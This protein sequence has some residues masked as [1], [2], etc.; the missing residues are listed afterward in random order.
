MT[1]R[2]RLLLGYGYLVG[3]LLVSTFSAVLGFLHL[4][5]GIDRVLE[6]N[7][8][9]IEAAMAMLETLERQ[10]SETLSALLAGATRG[11]T[12]TALDQDLNAALDR[13]RSHVTE[14]AEREA[15][16]A[17]VDGV[18]GFRHARDELLEQRADRPLAAYNEAVLPQFLLAKKRVRV[19]LDV[20]QE[21]MLAA[22]REAKATALRNGAWLGFLVAL[23]LLSLAYL[24]HAMQRHILS[25]IT[26]LR[27]DVE[28][29]TEGDPDRRLREGGDDELAAVARGVNCLVDSRLERQGELEARLALERRTLLGLLREAGEG[30]SLYDL[31]GRLRGVEGRSHDDGALVG[32]AT[33][34]RDEGKAFVEANEP[35]VAA[36]IGDYEVR[37]LKAGHDR[38][39]AW[40]AVPRASVEHRQQPSS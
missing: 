19:L 5:A 20:N 8:S 29:M 31:G 11:A 17:V 9:S 7:Y 23:A 14:D 37:L 30:A 22:D 32:I 36:E 21:A 25:R 34:I 13:A 18:E 33:W 10:D 27:D 39:V 15:L 4:S 40:L 24:S 26:R 35:R 38:P 1:L 2:L 12:L 6:E 28:R 16:A 3:L